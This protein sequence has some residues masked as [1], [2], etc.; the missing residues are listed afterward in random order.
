M[1]NRQ[2]L[3]ELQICCLFSEAAGMVP[4]W[5]IVFAKIILRI[6]ANDKCSANKYA[7]VD[8]TTGP[9]VARDGHRVSALCNP[10][11]HPSVIFLSIRIPLHRSFQSSHLPPSS[12]RPTSVT[13]ILTIAL[14]CNNR[15]PLRLLL[16]LLHNQRQSHLIVPYHGKV[17]LS[18][19][20]RARYLRPP[21][22]GL[23]NPC[24]ATP[25]ALCTTRTPNIATC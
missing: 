9:H 13:S 24:S 5:Q 6:L 4:F 16:L 23:L 21:F 11:Q 17:I 2:H 25:P 8:P 20:C 7:H 1:I 22:L 19:L 18:Q 10:S 15:P 14:S 12:P 3:L